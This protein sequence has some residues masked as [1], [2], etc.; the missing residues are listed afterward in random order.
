MSSSTTG[1]NVIH[2]PL[3][4]AHH[5]DPQSAARFVAEMEDSWRAK[6]E[7]A[8]RVRSWLYAAGRALLGTVLMAGAIGK[9]MTFNAT[10]AALDAFGLS[11]PGALLAGAIA[12]EFFG[13]LLLAIGY[14]VRRV[15]VGLAAYLALLTLILHSD[16]RVELNRSFALLT[17]A[18]IAAMMLLIAHGGGA[19]S[20]DKKAIR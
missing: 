7:R 15:G 3:H 6:E 16:L 1:A 12:I 18:F 17:L 4:H 9:V 13:G 2:H 5:H 8:K 19:H 20:L 10:R 11:A 14:Q